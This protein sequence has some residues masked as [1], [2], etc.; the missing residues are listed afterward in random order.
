VLSQIGGSTPTLSG[1]CAFGPPWASN[2]S[3]MVNWGTNGHPISI[4][5]QTDN[6]YPPHTVVYREY[7]HWDGDTLLFTSTTPSASPDNIKIG[8]FAELN[9][10]SG[11]IEVYDRDSAGE[12]WDAHGTQ[13]SGSNDQ[14]GR[15]GGLLG[16]PNPAPSLGII[17]EP[18]PE[19]LSGWASFAIQGVRA[20]DSGLGCRCRLTLADLP[21][22]RRPRAAF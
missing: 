22:A 14:F 17:S 1:A 18:R 5:D 4:L 6:T 11:V 13:S 7:L 8:G 15:I 2:N 10:P 19:N 21:Y 20:A 12:I 9:P 3:Y 16:N